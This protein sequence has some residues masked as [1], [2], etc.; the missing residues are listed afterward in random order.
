MLFVFVSNEPQM[1][2][3]ALTVKYKDLW[4][5]DRKDLNIFLILSRLSPV[6]LF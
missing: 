5:N 4:Q 2:L 1:F 3:F 6:C